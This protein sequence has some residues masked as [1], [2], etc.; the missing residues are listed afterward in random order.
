MGASAGWVAHHGQNVSAGGPDEFQSGGTAKEIV[1]FGGDEWLEEKGAGTK[2]IA[3]GDRFGVGHAGQHDEYGV[4]RGW[5][6]ADPTQ[7]VETAHWLH[8]HV[9]ENDGRVRGNG[10]AREIVKEGLPG[11][12]G[13]DG[14][15]YFAA[16]HDA[17]RKYK[18]FLRIVYNQDRLHRE[19]R[20]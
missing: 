6:V 3:F 1:Q 17:L 2:A 20:S 7:D 18:V 13:D 5:K 14:I 12:K 10:L 19:V 15:E 9:Q 16:E 11:G 4:F 8:D